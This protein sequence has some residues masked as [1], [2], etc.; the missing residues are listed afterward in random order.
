MFYFYAFLFSSC[1]RE[2]KTL[3]KAIKFIIFTSTVT[4]LAVTFQSLT[5]VRI[6]ATGAFGDLVS[7]DTVFRDVNRSTFGGF[8]NFVIFSLVL[9]MAKLSRREIH[10]LIGVPLLLIL[11]VGLVVTFGRMVWAVTSIAVFVA[12]LLLGKKSFVLILGISTITIILLVCIVSVVKPVLIEAVIDRVMSVER[13]VNGGGVSYEW[14]MQENK[15]AIEQIKSHPLTGV[16]F[17][18]VYAPVIDAA[19]ADIQTHHIHNAYLGFMLRFG[20][21]GIIFPFWIC[22]SV[23]ARIKKLLKDDRDN[24]LL[25]SIGSVMIVPVISGYTQPVWFEDVGVMF[26]ATMVAIL[27]IQTRLQKNNVMVREQCGETKNNIGK[28]QCNVSWGYPA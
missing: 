14:R 5:G 28:R 8:Q 23:W 9:I 4:A 11:I 27:I 7:A 25:I 3:D 1:I 15:F 13:D 17:G 18:G 24:S 6:L 21:L 22:F 19:T 20:V 26:I 2:K 16:S 12:S 10:V